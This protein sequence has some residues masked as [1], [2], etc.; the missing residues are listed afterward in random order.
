MMA[1]L[2]TFPLCSPDERLNNNIMLIVKS[3]KATHD[4][5]VLYNVEILHSVY[6][7]ILLM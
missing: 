5:R 6:H 2:P 4:C 3:H 7:E 1:W